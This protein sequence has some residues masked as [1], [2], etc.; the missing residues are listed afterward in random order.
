MLYSM[1]TTA[2]DKRIKCSSVHVAYLTASGSWRGFVQ[3]YDITT[4]MASKDD[5]KTA[6][7]EMCELYEDMLEEYGRPEHLS[8]KPLSNAQDQMMFNKVSTAIIS[9][10]GGLIDQ[11]SLYAEAI[12]A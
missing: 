8:F 7:Q 3:P 2:T 9:S 4:E 5:V 11:D 10:E 1:P 12:R 6:L